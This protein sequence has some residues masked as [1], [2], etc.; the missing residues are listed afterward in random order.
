[1]KFVIVEIQ[2]LASGQVATLVNQADTRM[3]AESIYH[4]ILAAAA[5]SQIP[6]HGAI[7]M[8]NEGYPLMHDCY[9]HEEVVS[10]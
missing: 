2:T 9:T 4:Q 10:E 8:S 6:R 1:M 7:L 3:Q 5:I